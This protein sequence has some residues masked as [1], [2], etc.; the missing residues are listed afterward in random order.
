[1]SESSAEPG[2]ISVLLDEVLA[3]LKLHSGATAID[4]TLGGGG[5]TAQILAQ[6]A[7]TGR[8]LGLD[9]D[10]DAI[11]RV[12]SRF[13]AEI[14]A[15][16]LVLAQS[17]FEQV[18]QVAE[19]NGFAQVDAMMMDLGVS[20]FQLDQAERGFSLMQPGPLDMRFD[21]QQSPS[22]ADI[23]NSWPEQELADLIYQ[24]GE[25][26][27]SRRIARFLVKNRPITTT[28][29]LAELVSRAA[30]GRRGERIHPAT[31]TFQALRIAV[32]RELE[33]LATVLPQSLSLLRPG[34]R[35]AVISFHSLEDRIVKQW[36][37]A[38]AADFV[39]DRMHPYGGY[40]RTPTVR[41]VTP[42]PVTASSLEV[43]RNPRSR[44]AKLRIVERL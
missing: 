17:A 13:Q 9:A 33:Q 40:A 28:E 22:A 37:Q 4:C 39:H 27:H 14:A 31:R 24:Y 15:G 16:R 38:E 29:E 2:H 44:S 7:P 1:M 21:P 20:S 19:A 23:V 35:L 42:K 34:G 30:G 32:N 43:E 11:E 6:T 18:S 5:H 41:I 25:E 8:V 12:A 26:R 10:P 3:G 36:A